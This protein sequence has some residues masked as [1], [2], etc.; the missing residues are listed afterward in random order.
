MKGSTTYQCEALNVSTLCIEQGV[1]TSIP[2]LHNWHSGHDQLTWVRA[3][4][5]APGDSGHLSCKKPF[6][7]PVT[8]MTSSM[9]I[10][11][12]YCLLPLPA[13]S[14]HYLLSSTTTC[15]L[16]PLPAASHRYLSPPTTTCCLLSL[17]P[18]P[19]LPAAFHH[20]LLSPIA[21]YSLPPLPA[22]FH[23]YL[24]PPTA[25]CCLS[26]LPT[27]SRHYPLPPTATY[28]LSLLSAASHDYLVATCRS[29]PCRRD[30]TAIVTSL[31]PISV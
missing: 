26:S 3:E 5:R 2:P 1:A 21:T 27:P 7:Q 15:S 20:Y 31:P 10:P 13:P 28:R 22:A 24:L 4:S 30:L 25:T 9:S 12:T 18:L 19:P 11:T 14:H 23:H 8:C 6:A 29:L 16:L 17:P